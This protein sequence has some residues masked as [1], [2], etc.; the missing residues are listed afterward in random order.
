[1]VADHRHKGRAET[2]QFA[3]AD[4]IDA[5][6]IAGLDWHLFGHFQQRGVVEHHVGRNVFFV[7]DRFAQFAQLGEQLAIVIAAVGFLV[8]AAARLQALMRGTASCSA[9]SPRNT[10]RA[11]SVNCSAECMAMF[12]VIKPVWIS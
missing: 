1:M 7:G 10:G 9:T 4:A 6:Q 3:L 5:Q 8:G 12:W 2:L 11:A